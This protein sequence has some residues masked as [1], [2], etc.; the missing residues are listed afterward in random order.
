M[1]KCLV[2]EPGDNVAVAIVK[3][4]SGETVVLSNGAS[5]KAINDIPFAHKMAI[6]PLVR[7]EK[8]FKYGE[9]I[10]EATEDIATG[11]HVHVHNIRSLRVKS[12]EAG[13]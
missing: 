10:G 12:L 9:V 5:L 11:Q 8:V 6:S 3:V 2:L 4:K 13:A 7:G 1:A